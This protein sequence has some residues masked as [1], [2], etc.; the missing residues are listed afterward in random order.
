MVERLAAGGQDARLPAR[1]ASPAD[2]G[3]HAPTHERSLF[4][5]RQY[6]ELPRPLVSEQARELLAEL[7]P[8]YDL[9]ARWQLYTGLR[10][11]E[12]LRLGVSDIGHRPA[13]ATLHHAI[14]VV[15]KGRKPGYVIAPASLLDETDGYVS[16]HRF[17]WLARA[18]RKGRIAEHNALFVN[19]RGAPA[20]KNAYQRAV[21][22]AGVACGFK[23]TT[24]LLRATFACMLLAA[25]TPGR[26]GR[27]DQPVIVVKVLLGHEHI[28]T[29]DRYLRAVAVDPCVLKD[30]LDTLLS[31]EGPS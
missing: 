1:T 3:R 30:V 28:E 14:E 20:G 2:A 29:T 31:E 19:A 27:Q 12:L 16:G 21:S 7:A 22:Q 26:R 8:P 23:A 13:S 25:R 6:E 15:R 4:V 5:L 17:A 10:I 18:R 9:M 24:H 11:S